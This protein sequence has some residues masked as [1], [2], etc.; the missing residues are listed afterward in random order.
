MAVRCYPS[1]NKLSSN[2]LSYLPSSCTFL[3]RGLYPGQRSESFLLFLLGYLGKK[4]L[5][6]HPTTFLAFLE[7]RIN[8]FIRRGLISSFDALTSLK[9]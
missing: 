2:A 3:R 9:F 6:L 5:L 8:W 1:S 7:Y 4:A